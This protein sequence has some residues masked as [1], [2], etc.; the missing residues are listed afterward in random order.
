VPLSRKILFGIVPLFLLFISVSVVIQNRFQERQ[1]MEEA[2]LSAH[3]YADI[4]KESLVSMM[5]KNYEVDSSFIDRVNALKQIDTLRI[6]VNNLRLRDELLTTERIVRLAQKQA[7]LRPRDRVE[8]SV[9]ERGEPFFQ[10]E[11]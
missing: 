3:T 4:V 10:R 6:F 2:Q 9:L 7:A 1:M 5:L 11:G 8:Q